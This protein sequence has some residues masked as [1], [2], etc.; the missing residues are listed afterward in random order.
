M[1]HNRPVESF[2]SQTDLRA[3]PEPRT[4][5]NPEHE[6]APDRPVY[7]V[8]YGRRVSA[9]TGADFGTY[10]RTSGDLLQRGRVYFSFLAYPHCIF[11]QRLPSLFGGLNYGV[12]FDWFRRLHDIPDSTKITQRAPDV[13]GVGV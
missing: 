2:P 12:V 10:Q 6:Q 7:R 4:V 3:R 13:A 1:N 5:R 11:F 9:L 8:R